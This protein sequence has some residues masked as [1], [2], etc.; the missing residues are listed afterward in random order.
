MN[1]SYDSELDAAKH[2]DFTKQWYA[3]VGVSL[4]LTMFVNAISPHLATLAGWVV[5]PLLRAW[6]RRKVVNQHQMNILYEG[7]KF[8]IET[9]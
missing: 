9:R 2:S 8:K 4:T 1:R 6:K 7:E 5:K 3:T